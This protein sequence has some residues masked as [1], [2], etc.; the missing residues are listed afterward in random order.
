[1]HFPTS[2]AVALLLAPVLGLAHPTRD[3]DS[4]LRIREVDLDIDLDLFAHRVRRWANPEPTQNAR[5]RASREG[6]RA[7]GQQQ[8]QQLGY[9]NPP[10]PGSSRPGTPETFHTAPNSPAGSRPNSPP[11]RP[12][13][14]PPRPNTPPPGTPPRAGSPPPPP[15]NGRPPTPPPPPS[16]QNSVQ[17]PPPPSR[18]NSGAG[19]PAPAT[20]P[21]GKGKWIPEPGASIIAG[22]A[23]GATAA[24]FIPQAAAAAPGL[25]Y[26]A[27]GMAGVAAGLKIWDKWPAGRK[28]D[29][30]SVKGQ[31]GR[32]RL[33]HKRALREL[34]EREEMD[35]MMDAGW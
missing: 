27:G 13:T 20:Q 7:L 6:Q 4:N 34:L 9:S 28:R 5:Q 29:L 33:M 14:P 10:S 8:A 22:G 1:M 15:N 12:N 35:E 18:Q 16:R 30:L 23:A 3:I 2:L 26:T 19:L 31:D 32:V 17:Y 11:P 25:R 21:N 24:S